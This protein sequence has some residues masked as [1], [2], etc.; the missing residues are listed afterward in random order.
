MIVNLLMRRDM[1]R[2]KVKPRFSIHEANKVFT[3][4]VRSTVTFVTNE[5]CLKYSKKNT[6]L[7]GNI[8]S[9]KK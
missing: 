2:L 6:G 1:V 5:N 9:K 8:N 7:R 4:E 3:C